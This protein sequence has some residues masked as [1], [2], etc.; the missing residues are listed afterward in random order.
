MRVFPLSGNKLL[1]RA[2]HVF[3]GAEITAS[4]EIRYVIGFSNVSPLHQHV[5]RS[6]VGE[7]FSLV[8]VD[9]VSVVV[10]ADVIMI[11]TARP[12]GLSRAAFHTLRSHCPVILTTKI[13]FIEDF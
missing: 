8:V 9:I 11:M 5:Q 1:H 7:K 2:A 4:P 3:V 6:C 13:H 12:N 10:I